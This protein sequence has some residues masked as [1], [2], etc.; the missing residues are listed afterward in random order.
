MSEIFNSVYRGLINLV[1]NQR[2]VTMAAYGK[3][4]G[5]MC[6]F[7][8]IGFLLQTLDRPGNFVEPTIVSGLAHDAEIVHRETFAPIVY[9]LKT[10]VR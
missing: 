6:P 1:G 2:S 9:I 10:K 7:V 3:S 4:I 5:G 8:I